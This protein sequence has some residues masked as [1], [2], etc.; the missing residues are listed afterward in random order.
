MATIYFSNTADS[1]DGSFRA[2]LESATESDVVAPDPTVFRRGERATIA[3][4]TYV[5]VVKSTTLVAGASRPRLASASGIT[6]YART[7]GA[8][9][10]VDGFEFVG[11]VIAYFPESSFTRCLFAGNAESAHLVQGVGGASI[12]LTDCIVVGSKRSGIYA[13]G[14]D[15]A[16]TLTRTTVAGCVQRCAISSSTAYSAIDSIVD[17]VCSESGFASAPPDD[18]VDGDGALPW[19]EW[20]LA[21]VAESR[22]A[23]GGASCA[24]A[25]DYLGIK[26]GREVGGATVYAVGALEVVEAD[27]YLSG[28]GGSFLCPSVWRTSRGGAT[29]PSTIES[30]VFFLDENATWQDAPPPGS[31]AIVAGRRRETLCADAT[32][33]R[34]AT[35]Q[36]AT[37]VFS[38]ADRVVSAQS[39]EVGTGVA[40]TADSASVGYLAVPSGVDVSNG[41]FSGVSPCEL[42]ARLT[43][44]R[45]VSRRAGRATLTWRASEESATIRIERRDSG[46]V[47]RFVGAPIAS[48]RELEAGEV[49]GRTSFRAFDG[50]RFWRD[51]A[52][53][54]SGVQY[55]VVASSVPSERAAQGWEAITTVV[56]TSDTIMV[57]QGITILARIFDAFDTDAPLLSDGA[58][59]ASV[60]Y[61]CYYVANGLFEETLA[62]VAGHEEVDAGADCVLEA[63]QQSDAWRVDDVGYS[64]VLTPDVRAAPLFE[65]AGEYRIK[66]VVRLTTGN[67][68][69]FYAPVTVVDR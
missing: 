16:L 67:P 27:Y 7:G 31:T 28:A 51:D 37:L 10:R 49:G 44:F 54:V 61:T 9:L 58:N 15:S 52:W 11:R 46:G 42:G 5:P 39:V 47:W 4:S 29:S 62:P 66:V 50:E 18:L 21:P 38:G 33:A 56:S 6:L 48:T 45:A 23:T 65:K 12:S 40:F 35:G 34:L 22:Y 68:V 2:A 3:L 43:T 20:N 57:G 30:G 8:F 69:T 17:P 13:T 19:E 26:R 59:V 36:D 14:A 24:G 32:L 25:C 60:T 64:F 41:V 55:R 1:G 63:L 53:S